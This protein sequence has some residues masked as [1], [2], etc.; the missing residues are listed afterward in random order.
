VFKIF[1]VELVTVYTAKMFDQAD[2]VSN[3]IFDTQSPMFLIIQ[4]I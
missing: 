3:L 2:L 4:L 1:K